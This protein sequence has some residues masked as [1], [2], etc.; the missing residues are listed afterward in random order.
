VE[1]LAEALWRAL[2]DAAL[3]AD[4]RARG[5]AQCRRFTWRASAQRLLACYGEL[6][7]R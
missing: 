5:L 1:A 4:L 3:R 2:D 6:T 7:T